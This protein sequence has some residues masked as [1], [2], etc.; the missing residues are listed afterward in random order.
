MKWRVVML[1]K[2]AILVISAGLMMS[3]MAVQAL[4]FGGIKLNSSLNEK[5]DA[6]VALLSATSKMCKV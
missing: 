3:P 1:R 2:V 4:G 5:L 6:D